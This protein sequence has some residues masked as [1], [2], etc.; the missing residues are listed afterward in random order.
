M[1]YHKKNNPFKQRQE[2]QPLQKKHLGQHFLISQD[3]INT[4]LSAIKITPETTIIEIGCG[5]GILTRALLASS[6]KA[7]HVIEI[8]ADWAHYIHDT[9]HDPRLTIHHEDA[10]DFDF[11]SL[12]TDGPLVLMANLPYV[13]TFPLFEK[14]AANH[15]I[16]DD[17]MV[18]IQEEAAERITHTSGRRCGAVSLFLQYYFTF[19]N[20]DKVPPKSF[21]PPPK[22]MSRLVRFQP[23]NE[24]MPLTDA[25]NFWLFVRACFKSPRQMLGNNLKRTL[26]SWQKLPAETLQLRAQ[27]LTVKEL[28]EI[29]LLLTE[30]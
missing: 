2:N 21:S 15:T 17:G 16:F 29:W 4:M 5:N 23:N 27:Q 1:A 13:I 22:V 14:L 24:L 19:T 9:I 30:Q 6:C 18:M 28:H 10:L 7:V 3:P 26:Y 11:S 25:K 20:Y 8:D 12:K